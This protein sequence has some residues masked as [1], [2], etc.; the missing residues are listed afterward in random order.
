MKVSFSFALL[1]LVLVG[2]TSREEYVRQRATETAHGWLETKYNPMDDINYSDES[3][4]VAE[5]ND[6]DWGVVYKSHAKCIGRPLKDSI[7]S[8]DEDVYFLMNYSPREDR[9]VLISQKDPLKSLTNEEP[10][11]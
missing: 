5:E 3:V 8:V 4:L 11:A 9:F 10:S 2:C 6:G 7:V 1:L